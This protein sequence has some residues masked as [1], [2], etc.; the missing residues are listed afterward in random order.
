MRV[1][2]FIRPRFSLEA[3]GALERTKTNS[4]FIFDTADRWFYYAG[5]RWDF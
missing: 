1:V 5:W 4:P 2:W 3:E